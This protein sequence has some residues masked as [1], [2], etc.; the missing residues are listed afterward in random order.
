MFVSNYFSL[1]FLAAHN[2]IFFYL[3][4]YSQTFFLVVYNNAVQLIVH[5]SSCAY[6]TQ[7]EVRPV[8]SVTSMFDLLLASR[9]GCVSAR[10]KGEA[11][12]KYLQT[13][14]GRE[15]MVEP[16]VSCA[17]LQEHWLEKKDPSIVLLDGT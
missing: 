1:C 5:V 11:A 8:A 9:N 7:V 4:I 2:Y 12:V 10:I 3:S 6:V 13:R 15:R 17:W 16:L 14:S